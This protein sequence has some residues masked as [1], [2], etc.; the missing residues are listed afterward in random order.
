[1]RILEKISELLETLSLRFLHKMLCNS[2]DPPMHR[3]S[4]GDFG[5]F[6]TGFSVV[7]AERSQRDRQVVPCRLGRV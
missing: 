4:C 7:G 3:G 1:M 5:F 2:L 6:S